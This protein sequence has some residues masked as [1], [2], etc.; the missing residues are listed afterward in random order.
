[1]PPKR[2][3]DIELE[4]AD[5]AAPRFELAQDAV[6]RAPGRGLHEPGHRT[7]EPALAGD[8]RLLRVGVV[9]FDGG[10]MLAEEFVVM[11]V[12][13]D[14]LAHVFPRVLLGVAPGSG[15]RRRNR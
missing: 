7:F 3:A 15:R 5:H 1:M 12:A 13:L 10:E 4:I 2:N 14:E 11:E 6:G 8:R 9:A